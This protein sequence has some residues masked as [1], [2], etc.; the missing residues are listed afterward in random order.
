[1]VRLKKIAAAAVGGAVLLGAAAGTGYAV[2]AVINPVDQNGVIHACFNT[3]R[4]HL[5]AVRPESGCE[6]GEN[7]LTWSKAGPQ[8]E[9]G[10]KGDQGDPG[11]TGLT[12]IVRRSQT[13]TLAEPNTQGYGDAVYSATAVH[14]H[15]GEKPLSGGI[16]IYGIPHGHY[17]VGDSHP[18]TNGGVPVGWSATA[19]HNKAGATGSYEVFVLC[20][21]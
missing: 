13:H 5:R 21:S 16:A 6:T 2:N 3:T 1:M 19:V 14:C 10:D 11:G 9:K 15:A 4:G 17:F 12:N 18:V 8:G 20:A 7:R